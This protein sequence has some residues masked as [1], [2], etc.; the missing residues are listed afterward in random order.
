MSKKS[1]APSD[2]ADKFM[3]RLPD[4]MRDRIKLAAERN[5]RSMN[6]EIVRALE[7]AFPEEPSIDDVA[8]DIIE[9]IRVLRIFK[10]KA[11]LMNLADQLDHLMLDLSRERDAPS[12]VKDAAI[13][14]IEERGKF[15]RYTPPRNSED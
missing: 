1:P 15:Y 11:L 3:L 12:E 7:N 6:A 14:H 10:G 5:G 2:V 8:Q 4:G 13:Q 9:A